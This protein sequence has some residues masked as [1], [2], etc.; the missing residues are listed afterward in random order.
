MS[1]RL[2]VVGFWLVFTAGMAFMGRNVAVSYTLPKMLPDNDPAMVEYADFQ[3][4][5]TQSANLIVLGAK[6]ESFFTPS[7][8]N[9]WRELAKRIEGTPEVVSVLS[10]H[11]ALDLYMDEAEGEAMQPF[12]LM[13]GPVKSP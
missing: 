4:E 1:N 2:F 13:V 6:D 3:S 9:Q 8:L 10:I 11:N 7:V 5:F 12:P